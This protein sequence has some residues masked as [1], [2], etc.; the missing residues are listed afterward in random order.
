M[1]TLRDILGQHNA[2]R[3]LRA[4]L[5]S[6]RVHH[7]WIFHGPHGVGKRTTA[8]AFAGALLDPTTGPDLSGV[9]APDP[10]SETQRLIASGMHPDLHLITKEL[11]RYS[12]D[13]AIRERKLISIPKEVI[14]QHLLA[15]ASLAPRVQAGAVVG[16]A[17]IVDE[18][19]LLND[20]T[21]NAMLKTLEEPAP[22]TVIILVT[23]SPEKLLPTIRS[24]CQRI[25][26]EPLST[27]EMR[28]WMRSAPSQTRE[29]LGSDEAAWVIDYAAGSPGLA[30]IAI[31]GRLY[32]WAVQLE[33]MLA[34]ADAGEFSPELGERM[35]KFID[36]WAKAQV[37]KNKNASKEAANKAGARRMLHLLAERARRQLRDDAS[38]GVDAAGALATIDLVRAA[39]RH[40][41]SNVNLALTMEHLAA[42]MAGKSDFSVPLIPV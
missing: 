15:P 20:T 7:A 16:K 35:T 6:Q 2:L 28:A 42:R 27:E 5:E 23:S 25:A 18:A 17:F 37:E 39:E 34:A 36:E 11:A 31:E 13:R 40:I 24:R 14:E 22:G 19:E 10:D 32:D 9:I 8:E 38:R 1:P 30:M 26:F 41:E 12:D 33:P 4:A 21:Q 29:K 3:V